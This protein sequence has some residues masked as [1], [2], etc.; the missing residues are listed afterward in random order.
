M[1]LEIE[2]LY[3][4]LDTW[5]F[6]NFLETHCVGQMLKVDSIVGLMGYQNDWW[7][8]LNMNFNHSRELY[9]YNRKIRRPKNKSYRFISADTQSVEIRNCCHQLRKYITGLFCY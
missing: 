6:R 5:Y 8:Q 2:Y 1:V 4:I 3:R 9:R 7:P